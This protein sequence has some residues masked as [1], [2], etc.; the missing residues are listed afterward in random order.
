MSKAPP[1]P[2]EQ[3]GASGSRPHVS[4]RHAQSEGAKSRIG[5]NPDQQGQ[6]ANT[7]KNAPR[8]GK[9]QDR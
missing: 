8:W 9:T 1:I 5:R 3:Q 4:G 7:E 6:S 2:S